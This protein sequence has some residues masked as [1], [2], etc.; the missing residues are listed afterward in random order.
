MHLWKQTTRE[1]IQTQKS[2]KTQSQC[3]NTV[4]SKQQGL[5]KA[6]FTS[7][8]KISKFSSLPQAFITF[9][10][11]STFIFL[12]KLLKVFD[13]YLMSNLTQG[14]G[15]LVSSVITIVGKSVICNVKYQGFRFLQ[16]TSKSTLFWWNWHKNLSENYFFLEPN[17]KI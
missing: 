14:Y 9:F 5:C 8:F 2:N 15:I 16:P 3:K 17:L 1:R 12:K 7:F 11:A 13:N 4:A 6:S 10:S